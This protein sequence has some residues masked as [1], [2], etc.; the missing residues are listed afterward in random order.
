[1]PKFKARATAYFSRIQNASETSFFFSDGIGGEDDPDTAF[2][3]TNSFVA[4]TVTGLNK[5]NIGA[6]LGL[7][8]Q[9]TSTIK[10]IASAA[11]GEYIYDNNPN[12]SINI[13]A[14]AT[15]E[16]VYPLKNYGEATLKGYRQ[17]GMPQQAA[18]LGVEYRDPKFWWIG[19]NVNYLGANYID[20]A[21][22]ARTA[23]FF[24]NPEDPFGLPFSEITPERAR[25]LLQQEKFDDFT[26]FNLVGGKSWRLY[27]KTIGFFASVNNVFDVTYKTGGFEQ[28]RNGNYRQ[29]NQD[30]SSGT[31]AFGSKY[32]YG[33]GR[34]YFVNLY[35]NF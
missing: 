13:D 8:Y 30:V 12:V 11:Y 35:V 4:E 17:P 25:E 19:A 24:K 10:I 15:S 32:F 2:N 21:P 22:I 23:N 29:L 33:Y 14:L 9:I 16:N 27:G 7:E 6:E 26:L 20:V 1:M 28:A 3:E 34:T 5:R 18:S 31:P